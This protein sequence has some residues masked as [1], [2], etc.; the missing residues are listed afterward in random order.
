VAY[1]YASL[2]AIAVRQLKRISSNRKTRKLRRNS[3][4]NQM[5]EVHV[6][7]LGEA[8]PEPEIYTRLAEAMRLFPEPPAAL[9]ELA[10]DALTPEGGAMFLGALQELAG[11]QAQPGADP[12]LRMLFWAYRTLGPHL[13]APSLVAVWLQS[14][15]NALVR[16]AAVRRTLGPD[17]EGKS[18]F[19]LASE[20]FRR[21]LAHPEGVEIARLNPTTNL[22]DHIGYADGRIRLA[23]EAMLTELQRAVATPPVQDADF[24]FV[25]AAGLRTR[26]T[27]N[28]IQRDPAW[29]KGRGPHCA[30]NL[31]PNDAHRVGV[32][33][34]DTVRVV[35]R[36]GAI[37]LPAQ[38]DAKLLDGHVWM[39]NGFGMQYAGE[40]TVHVDGAN[41]N[42][43]TDATDRDPFTGIPHH[44]YVR[45]RIEGVGP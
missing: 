15:L 25:L 18:P 22:E 2:V 4:T 9:H 8:L 41:Q 37:T 26:W 44:R 31:S 30:L 7:A 20:L 16:P 43:L 32:R 5:K 14:G 12:T 1:A 13:A 27:A 21:I 19:E 33:N 28:T 40:G 3:F 42:E 24:P 38:V 17:W 39:P 35:T 45:C 11:R 36:R 10:K 23:P 34:G 6:P 29:R